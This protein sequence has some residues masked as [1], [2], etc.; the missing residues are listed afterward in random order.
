MINIILEALNISKSYDNVKI[1]DGINI[2]LAKGEVVSLL[3]ES[4]CGKSTVLNIIAGLEGPDNGKVLISGKDTTLKVGKVSYMPQR[5]LLLPYKNI[6]DNVSLPLI[7]KGEKKSSAR[8]RALPLFKV[9]SLEG[10]E[11]K[12]PNE[13][14]GGMRQRAAFLRTYL[15]SNNIF[16]LDE[17]FSALDAITKSKMH[18][19]YL[20]L[21]DKMSIST[22]LVTHDIDEAI[23]LSNRIYIIKGRPARIVDEINIETP[24]LNGLS[25]S[26]LHYKNQI[27][28]I[29]SS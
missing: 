4:G 22:V 26:F 25:E 18:R 5:D 10:C 24:S 29:L 27:L 3:G 16:L 20:E 11:Y 15:C 13:L 12:Y 1:V 14:S 19:W 7:L 21:I 23:Y 28:N 6:I 17:P 8:K 9:F 2:S